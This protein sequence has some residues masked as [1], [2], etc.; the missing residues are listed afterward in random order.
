MTDMNDEIRRALRRM[1]PPAGFAERVL[2]RA[3]NDNAS[4]TAARHDT[5]PG[6]L[7][8]PMVRW[9]AAA[10]LAIAVASGGVWYRA[11][12]RQAQ[13]ED[14]RRQVLIGLRIASGKLQSVQ[15]KVNPRTS[16]QTDPQTNQRRAQQRANT[17]E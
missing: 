4:A 6:L 1:E 5:T 11:E 16:P 12:Q 10:A 15:L 9:A 8:G 3:V 7:R 17:G 2:E 13:G 14:A